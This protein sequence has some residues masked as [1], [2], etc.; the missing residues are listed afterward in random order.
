MRDVSDACCADCAPKIG[1]GLSCS[2][3]Q[4]PQLQLTVRMQLGVSGH[5][6]LALEPHC[7]VPHDV[8]QIGGVWSIVIWGCS[9]E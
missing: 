1:V 3:L 2:I 4:P 5:G 9:D 7:T 8:W 6:Q